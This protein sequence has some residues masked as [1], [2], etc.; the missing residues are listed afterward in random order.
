M[1]LRQKSLED[2]RGIEGIAA[3]KYFTVLSGVLSPPWVFRNG[4]GER[5]TYENQIRNRAAALASHLR[6][7]GEYLPFICEH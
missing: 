3:M 5:S 6:G 1:V 4:T 7:E 2:V